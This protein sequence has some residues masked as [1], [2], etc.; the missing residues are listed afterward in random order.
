[1]PGFGIEGGNALFGELEMV[2]AVE[3]AFL[4][5]GIARNG[6]AVGFENLGR[7]IIQRRIAQ[8]DETMSFVR[9]QM[10]S[11]SILMSASVLFRG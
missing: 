11:P 2:G 3:M 7:D 9:P 10:F 1:M 4:R 6:A 8:P 5:L